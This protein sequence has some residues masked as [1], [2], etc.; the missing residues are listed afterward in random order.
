MTEERIVTIRS[1][2]Y[3]VDC[4]HQ[5]LSKDHNPDVLSEPFIYELMRQDYINYDIFIEKA[6][7]PVSELANFF[8]D[9]LTRFKEEF[10]KNYTPGYEAFHI[11]QFKIGLR[12]IKYSCTVFNELDR[13]ESRFSLNSP[14]SL[15]MVDNNLNPSNWKYLTESQFRAKLHLSVDD[16]NTVDR[17]CPVTCLRNNSIFSL[18]GHHASLPYLI[19]GYDDYRS[20][21]EKLFLRSDYSKARTK[22]RFFGSYTLDCL[23]LGKFVITRYNYTKNCKPIFDAI[24][25]Y[26][27]NFKDDP[28][29]NYEIIVTIEAFPR[30]AGQDVKLRVFFFSKHSL[31][32]GYMLNGYIESNLTESN[33]LYTSAISSKLITDIVG[34]LNNYY[35]LNLSPTTSFV[36]RSLY[37][38]TKAV[39]SKL[40]NDEIKPVVPGYIVIPK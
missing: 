28:E 5:A 15:M 29:T 21:L 22:K 34:E 19:V 32:L 6:D 27:D 24:K 35:W 7:E 2:R 12:L 16:N 10:P 8:Y 1:F 11:M 39:Y 14:Y 3:Y 17:I 37:N 36:D 33:I 30:K 25:D 40:I 4:L 13:I 18:D 9:G 20:N 31:R 38:I 23:Y 26:M